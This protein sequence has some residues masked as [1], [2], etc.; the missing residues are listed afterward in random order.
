M[1]LL[2]EGCCRQTQHGSMIECMRCPVVASNYV[3][4]FYSMIEVLY[5]SDEL[6]KAARDQAAL[7]D[8]TG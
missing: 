3:S 8:T 6:P 5:E 4:V 2:L 1:Y 7:V